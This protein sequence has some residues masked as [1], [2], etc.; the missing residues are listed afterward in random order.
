MTENKKNIREE[1][2]CLKQ[3]DETNS[4]EHKTI[5]E[6]IKELKDIIAPI[7]E[8]YKTVSRMTKW[9]MAFLV[10]L[11]IVGGIIWTWG[12]VIKNFL[13]GK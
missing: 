12:N 11:S 7:S 2:E 9:L 8:T 13:Q 10:F 3:K 6:T 5:L 1:I 4:S